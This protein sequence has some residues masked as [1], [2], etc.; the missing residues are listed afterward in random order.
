MNQPNGAYNLQLQ[1]LALR[2]RFRETLA[3]L[4][5]KHLVHCVSE[6]HISMHS[7]LDSGLKT[8]IK[9]NTQGGGYRKVNMTPHSS[10][11]PKYAL[12]ESLIDCVEQD[13]IGWDRQLSPE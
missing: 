2:R 9:L 7:L 8:T 12:H 6:T 4:E 10:M 13:Y 1:R 3:S 5:R 11:Q